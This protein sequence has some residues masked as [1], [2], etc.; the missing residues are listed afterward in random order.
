[1]L[2]IS[3]ARDPTGS[4]DWAAAAHQYLPNSIDVVFPYFAHGDANACTLDLIAAFIA[5][6]DPSTLRVDCAEQITP[7]LFLVSAAT[8]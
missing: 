7:P 4:A 6:P 8:R 3:G 2:L 5:R 1:V